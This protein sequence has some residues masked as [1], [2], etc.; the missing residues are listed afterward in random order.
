M[1]VILVFFVKVNGQRPIA[2]LEHLRKSGTETILNQ[3]LLI[4]H[5]AQVFLSSFSGSVSLVTGMGRVQLW[6]GPI[7][8]HAG[9]T[10]FHRFNVCHSDS[11]KV[12]RN[13]G[14]IRIMV[15]KDLWLLWNHMF[16][17]QPMIV[18]FDIQQFLG[19]LLGIEELRWCWWQGF[20]D[21]QNVQVGRSLS[22]RISVPGAGKLKIEIGKFGRSILSRR[23]R[24]NLWLR[25]RV[26]FQVVPHFPIVPVGFKFSMVSIATP[27]E[28]TLVRRKGWWTNGCSSYGIHKLGNSC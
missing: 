3:P 12:G 10:T 11:I 24:L 22:C 27:M 8:N 2:V 21:V 1:N 9:V 20:G 15:L 5:S 14:A 7:L 26:I 19:H 13:G 18:G 23:S 16:A 25:R 28:T 6:F 17:D 4:A